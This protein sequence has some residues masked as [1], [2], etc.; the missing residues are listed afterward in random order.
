M[1]NTE[2]QVTGSMARAFA[3]FR[4]A[5]SATREQTEQ[6]QR[7]KRLTRHLLMPTRAAAAVAEARERQRRNAMERT[8]TKAF[9][10]K[11]E[12]DARAERRAFRAFK[13]A[14]VP[15]R[16]QRT[17]ELRA[18]IK[19]GA[20]LVDQVDLMRRR[21]FRDRRFVDKP[22]ALERKMRMLHGPRK[23][24]LEQGVS[25]A[26]WYRRQALKTQGA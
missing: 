7:V 8:A 15:D 16:R 22:E 4:T 2:D 23:N 17:R 1:S 14:I 11:A 13:C 10:R 5:V 3:G 26:T 12:A 24:W 25:R 9:T 21:D 20:S 6:A 19:A 18:A